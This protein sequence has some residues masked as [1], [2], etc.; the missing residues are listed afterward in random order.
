MQRI[1]DKIGITISGVCALHCLFAPITLLLIPIFGL[2]VTNEHLLHEIFLTLILPTALIA[3]TMGCR[4]H[5]D[6]NV[7]LLAAIG[8][9]ILFYAV[10]EHDTLGDIMVR[11]VSLAGSS[12]IIFSHIRNYILCQKAGCTH[13]SH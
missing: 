12:V 2:S 9:L 11:I 3:I 13:E 6:Y 10:V 7:A 1:I 4:R 5:K 8:I